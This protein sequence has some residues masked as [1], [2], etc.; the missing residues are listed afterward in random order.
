MINSNTNKVI[1]RSNVRAEVEPTSSNLMIDPLTAPEVVTSLLPPSNYPEENEEDHPVAEEKLPNA[2]AS[3]PKYKMAIL[4]PN[5]LV[6]GL[7]LFHKKMVNVYELE[8]SK[9]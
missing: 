8:W 5:D 3:L 9:L 4:D 2:S 6:G 7:F 1:S